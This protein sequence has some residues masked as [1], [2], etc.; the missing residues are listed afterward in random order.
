ME[1]RD[2]RRHHRGGVALDDDDIAVVVGQRPLHPI[3]RATGHQRGRLT[4]RHDP[5]VEVGSDPEETE[6]VRA[7]RRVLGRQSD[8]T[9]DLV[10]PSGE[11]KDDRCQ[12]DRLRSRADDDKDPQSAAMTHTRARLAPPNRSTATPRDGRT[13]RSPPGEPCLIDRKPIALVA[14]AAS[15]GAHPPAAT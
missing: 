9:L 12:L 2:G 4:G 15:G 11:G 13:P 5:E 3:Q 6:D 7:H 1:G 10:W 8:E 14:H